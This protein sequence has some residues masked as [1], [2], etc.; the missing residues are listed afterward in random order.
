MT[1]FFPSIKCNC[2]WTKLSL[3]LKSCKNTERK[4]TSWLLNA[5]QVLS[6]P[7]PHCQINPRLLSSFQTVLDSLESKLE[8]WF[9]LECL[10]T[11]SSKALCS[12]NNAEQIWSL[13]FLSFSNCQTGKSQSFQEKYEDKKVLMLFA[14]KEKWTEL[15]RPE[16]VQGQCLPDGCWQ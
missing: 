14:I 15:L 1:T 16:E 4:K 13:I 10:S 12:R 3:F 2:T 11:V 5:R 6:L 9:P 7:T 8:H